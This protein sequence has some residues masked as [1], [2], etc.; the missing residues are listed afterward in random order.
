MSPKSRQG[1]SLTSRLILLGSSLLVILLV[2]EAISRVIWEGRMQMIRDFAKQL[3]LNKD[4]PRGK[5]D[6]LPKLK[7]LFVVATPNI[8][9]TTAG[10]LFENN[11]YGF[12]GP[13]RP[14]VKPDGVFRVAVIGDSITMGFGVLYE[15]T[16]A[17][18]LEA[19][20]GKARRDQSYQVLNVG[21]SGTETRT[22]I[23]RFETKALPFD[24]DMV[25]Y[26]YTLN[27]IEGEYYRKSYQG[28]DRNKTRFMKSPLRLWRIIGPK[29]YA[30]MDTVLAPVG[31]YPGE[32][33]DNYMNNPMAWNEVLTG[34]D[35]LT[36]LTR[37]RQVCGVVL[38]HT[39]L[40]SLNFLHPYHAYYEMV[41]HAASER[42]LFPVTSY[43]YFDGRRATD[44]WITPFDAHPDPEGHGLLHDALAA[45]LNDL[46]A[47]CW[48]AR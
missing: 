33:A 41:A 20:L 32:L 16:Y 5:W 14:H 38:L 1:T 48:S 26:G 43:D 47:R 6:D 39:R 25:I 45:G 28:R 40:E 34:L 29:V 4:K 11:Q 37:E 17:A 21:L 8:R 7:G 9:G 44:L 35:R 27:D 42:G 3:E 22:I 15:E 10:V 24:P 31:S 30:M 19:S 36:V 13:G 46:P 12:R 2:S 18:R 23:E